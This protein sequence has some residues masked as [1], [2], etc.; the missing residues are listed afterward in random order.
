MYF[1]KNLHNL[2][3]KNRMN[4]ISCIKFK[5]GKSERKYLFCVKQN[6]SFLCSSQFFGFTYS[7]LETRNSPIEKKP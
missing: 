7:K 4:R 5:E 3:E 6:S 2:P 1:H